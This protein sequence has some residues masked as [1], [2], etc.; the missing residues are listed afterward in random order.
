MR[1][2]STNNVL[3][4]EASCVSHKK[5]SLLSDPDCGAPIRAVGTANIRMASWRMRVVSSRSE[6]VIV[7]SI[8]VDET[9]YVMMSGGQ[10]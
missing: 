4:V 2:R 8:F 5:V 9:K 3:I 1:R 6:F 7:L 10:G